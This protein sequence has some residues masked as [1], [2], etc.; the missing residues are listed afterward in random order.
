LLSLFSTHIPASLLLRFCLSKLTRFFFPHSEK[1][2]LSPR[3]SSHLSDQAANTY[4][5]MAKKHAKRARSQSVASS[6]T[7]GRSVSPV[8]RDLKGKGK[9]TAA[10]EDEEEDDEGEGKLEEEEL[11]VSIPLLVEP[12]REAKS[13]R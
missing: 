13:Y 9:A 2:N 12:V 5:E 7:S 10:E 6:S 4:D 1:V 11:D 8:K 3:R